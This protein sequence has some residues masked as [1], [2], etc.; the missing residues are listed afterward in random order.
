MAL[1][2]A[3]KQALK[4]VGKIDNKYNLNKIFIQK[5]V[6]PG[7]RSRANKIV[8][9][10]G[11]LGGGYRIVRFVESLYAPDTPGNG[12][13]NFPQ[14]QPRFTSRKPYQTRSGQ[15][16]RT[17]SRYRYKCS[18]SRYNRYSNSRSR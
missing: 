5:Y 11:A 1:L 17:S 18:P 12:A 16:R 3:V 10:A 2:P 13:S 14:K 7:Y 6:P 15:A 9:I 8:E 4:I